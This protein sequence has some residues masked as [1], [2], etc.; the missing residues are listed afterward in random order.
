MVVRPAVGVDDRVV[1]VAAHDGATHD[2]VVG[3][4]AVGDLHLGRIE[5]LGQIQHRGP[6][7]VGALADVIAHVVCDFGM[8][9]AQCILVLGAQP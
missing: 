9:D 3:I 5:Q 6:D 4:E 2:V 7:G 8:R 1:R